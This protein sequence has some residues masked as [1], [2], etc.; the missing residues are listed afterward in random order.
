MFSKRDVVI[1]T[2]EDGCLEGVPKIFALV[3]PSAVDLDIYLRIAA[4]EDRVR[5]LTSKWHLRRC[6]DSEGENRIRHSASDSVSG[7]R[8]AHLMPMAETVRRTTMKR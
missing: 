1:R 7:K 5:R 2:C 8:V 6:I 4:D 3:L